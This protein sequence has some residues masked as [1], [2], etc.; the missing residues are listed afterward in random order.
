M[1]TSNKRDPLRFDINVTPIQNSEPVVE[2]KQSLGGIHTQAGGHV[3]VVGQRGAEADQT[4][5]LLS[6]LHVSDGSR[7]Q[8]L[9]DGATIVVQ[10]V[11]FIL[12]NIFTQS[13]QL[14]PVITC[15]ILRVFYKKTHS[16]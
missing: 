2:V 14:F 12:N 7:H 8:R 9:Q 15:F 6:Q 1:C 13:L 5:V 4:H 10:Q 11:D 16:Q 3:L